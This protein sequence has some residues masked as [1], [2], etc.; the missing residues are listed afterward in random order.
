MILKG[1][2]GQMALIEVAE[3]NGGTMLEIAIPADDGENVADG[4]PADIGRADVH[5]KMTEETVTPA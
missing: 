4:G 5:I 1:G 2:G 3:S